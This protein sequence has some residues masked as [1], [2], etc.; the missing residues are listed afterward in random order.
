MREMIFAE[1]PAFRRLLEVLRDI[2]SQ[3][4]EG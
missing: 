4:N 3:V 1:A 2:E